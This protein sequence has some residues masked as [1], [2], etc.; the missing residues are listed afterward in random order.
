[1]FP[2]V[3]NAAVEREVVPEVE[4]QAR[5]TRRAPEILRVVALPDRQVGASTEVVLDHHVELLAQEPTAD[6]PVQRGPITDF[7]LEPEVLRD[8]PAIIV[9]HDL[10]QGLG[11]EVEV[12]VHVAVVGVEAGDR[13]ELH[14]EGQLDAAVEVEPPGVELRG[15]RPIEVAL[16]RIGIE[17]LSE[18]LRD[19]DLCQ[20]GRCPIGRI[21]AGPV[22][23]TPECR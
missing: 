16:P 15:P 19:R 17:T 4:G 23:V 9:G 6:F 14:S 8:L 7:T 10:E 12:D 1:M 11:R 5:V 21:I 18:F 20:V 2:V 13:A 3:A 22:G